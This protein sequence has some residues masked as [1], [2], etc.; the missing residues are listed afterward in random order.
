MRILGLQFHPS[1]LFTSL[2]VS[3]LEGLTEIEENKK[4]VCLVA[5]LD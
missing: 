5:V 4:M 3:L 1:L 2:I